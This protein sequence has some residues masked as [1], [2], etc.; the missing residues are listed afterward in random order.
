ML[1]YLVAAVVLM[2]VVASGTSGPAKPAKRR[3]RGMGGTA[4]ARVRRYSALIQEAHQRYPSVRASLLAGLIE[5]ESGGNP[6]ATR[7]ECRSAEGKLFG[8]RTACPVGTQ[9]LD[10]KGRPV[11][12]RGLV[13]FLIGTGEQ[14]GLRATEDPAT[15]ERRDPSKAIPAAARFLDSLIHKYGTEER[16]LSAYNTGRPDSAHGAGYASRVQARRE[17][18]GDLDT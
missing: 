8:Q 3:R 18:Y 12:S 14:Y 13:Q 10:K 11:M 5:N 1:G 16:A 15:D 6:N 17:K 4:E 9:R 7:Y 2:L